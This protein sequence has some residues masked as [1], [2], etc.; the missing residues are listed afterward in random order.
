MTSSGASSRRVAHGGPDAWPVSRGRG[1]GSPHPHGAADGHRRP[2]SIRERGEHAR[3][4]GPG[5]VPRR[6]DGRRSRCWSMAGPGTHVRKMAQRPS[7][8]GAGGATCSQPTGVATHAPPIGW[9]DRARAWGV[10]GCTRTRTLPLIVSSASYV[11]LRRSNARLLSDECRRAP[12][13]RRADRELEEIDI[14]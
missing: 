6:I 12:A 7:R 9:H 4:D 11:R 13:S 3:P 2:A 1:S 8:T 10:F 14:T 5:R